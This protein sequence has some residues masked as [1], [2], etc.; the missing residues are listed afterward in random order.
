MAL[1]LLP[2]LKSDREDEVIGTI[3][4]DINKTGEII[5]FENLGKKD[6]SYKIK[7]L[8]EG[9][10]YLLEFT[11]DPASLS[12]FERKIKLT[13]EILRYLIIKKEE[14]RQE[15]KPSKE[16][17]EVKKTSKV[18]KTTVKRK[19]SKRKEVEEKK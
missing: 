18:K 16:D 13:D 1:I 14:V 10:Y 7:K 17:I 15:V 8:L 19:T 11:Y 2:D 9:K 4:T 12:A 5:N 6:L 3:K